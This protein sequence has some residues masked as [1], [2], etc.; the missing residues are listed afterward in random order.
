MR[1]PRGRQVDEGL[2]RRTVRVMRERRETTPKMEAGM[3]R[4]VESGQE[5][6]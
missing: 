4:M 6:R 2:A 5:V 1:E 3:E